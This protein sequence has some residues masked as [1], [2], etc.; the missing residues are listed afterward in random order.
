MKDIFLWESSVRI[1]QFCQIKR[2]A[3]ASFCRVTLNR[4]F[5][6]LVLETK[7][8]N[9]PWKNQNKTFKKLVYS[10][11]YFWE[12]VFVINSLIHNFPKW[13]NTL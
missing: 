10:N 4:R 1:K 6:V 12:F 5:F 2:I 13:S 7:Y 8:G 9:G 3:R 11:S